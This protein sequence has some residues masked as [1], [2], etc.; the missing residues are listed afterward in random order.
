ML[1]Q[2]FA[3]FPFG[4]LEGFA[5]TNAIGKVI[6]SLQEV[7]HGDLNSVNGRISVYPV[8]DGCQLAA[9]V[10]TLPDANE[11]SQTGIASPACSVF[12]RNCI[13]LVTH[14]LYIPGCS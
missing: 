3:A 4:V 6:P 7:I 9:V 13:S 5:A 12:Y 11:Q 10:I 1:A 8:N 14:E 2:P